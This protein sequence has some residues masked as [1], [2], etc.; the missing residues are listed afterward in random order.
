[1]KSAVTSVLARLPGAQLFV[2]DAIVGHL[3]R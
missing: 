1:M 2:L 3:R